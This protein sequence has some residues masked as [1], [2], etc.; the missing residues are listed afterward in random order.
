MEMVHAGQARFEELCEREMVYLYLEEEYLQS[1]SDRVKMERSYCR[2]TGKEFGEFI[3][4]R[5]FNIT[6]PL[7]PAE[8]YEAWDYIWDGES[9]T[10]RDDE[11]SVKVYED[12]EQWHEEYFH[13]HPGY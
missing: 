9:G 1:Q 12:T 13:F 8:L 10:F 3:L 4:A 11:T 5:F 6:E 2:K 7:T